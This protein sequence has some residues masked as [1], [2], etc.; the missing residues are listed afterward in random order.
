MTMLGLQDQKTHV[1]ITAGPEN[2]VAIT[3]EPEKQRGHH[4]RN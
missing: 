1:V 2:N 3:A 4:Y